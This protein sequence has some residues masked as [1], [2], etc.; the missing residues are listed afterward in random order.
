MET[1]LKLFFFFILKRQLGVWENA[2][3]YLRTPLRGK[4]P[5]SDTSIK[6]R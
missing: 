3:T 1:G 2:T 6:A 5:K 4:V